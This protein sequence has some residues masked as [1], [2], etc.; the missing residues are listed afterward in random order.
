MLK[1]G[2]YSPTAGQLCTEV[3]LLGEL[4]LSGTWC[5]IISENRAG[6][7][8]VCFGQY[9]AIAVHDPANLLRQQKY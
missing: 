8:K 7:Y 9:Q 4:T 2:Y 1:A 5:N 3:N 6:E